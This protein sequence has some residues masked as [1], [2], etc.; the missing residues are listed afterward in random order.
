MHILIV[1][2]EERVR[3][4]VA[5]LLEQAGHTTCWASTGAG[6]LRLLRSEPVDLMLLDVV[7]PD[8]SGWEVRRAQLSDR[9]TA[10]IPVI[11]ISGLD[12]QDVRN[13]MASVLLVLSKPVEGPALLRAIGHIA[14]LNQFWP[15][16]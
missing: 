14:T 9:A 3:Q 1:E 4:A 10:R 7:L 6:A 16:R 5:R 12:P 11:V 13:P 15:P 8:L 2:D